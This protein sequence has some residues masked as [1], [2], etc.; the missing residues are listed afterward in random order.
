M[1]CGAESESN[2]SVSSSTHP[3]LGR[4]YTPLLPDDSSK[5][6]ANTNADADTYGDSIRKN[7]VDSNPSSKNAEG[8]HQ[9]KTLGPDVH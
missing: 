9:L 6:G 3:F 8:I 1:N 5:S 7:S 4:P 2:T